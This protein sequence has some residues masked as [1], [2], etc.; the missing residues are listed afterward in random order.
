MDC[1]NWDYRSSSPMQGGDLGKDE[2]DA[3]V[4]VA[5]G[6]CHFWIREPARMNT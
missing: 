1:Y 6:T 2:V 5:S 3:E 4:D